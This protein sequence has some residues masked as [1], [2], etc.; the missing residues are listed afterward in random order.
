[1]NPVHTV[2][3]FYCIN[4]EFRPPLVLTYFDII[5]LF[6]CKVTQES[7]HAF[8]NSCGAFQVQKY[9]H[10]WSEDGLRTK[11]RLQWK[12]QW[13]RSLLKTVISAKPLVLLIQ[14]LECT[15][16][17][18]LESD[19]RCYL[20]SISFWLHYIPLWV[21][22]TKHKWNQEALTGNKW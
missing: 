15:T 10:M 14:S 1:M 17:F 12:C 21:T 2:G 22:W 19:F 4:L 3:N 6:Y 11:R 20:I 18:G 9:P 8:I 16:S 13:F 7:G 5:E